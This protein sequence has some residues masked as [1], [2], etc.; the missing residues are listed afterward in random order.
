MKLCDLDLI[1]IEEPQNPVPRSPAPQGKDGHASEAEE[2]EKLRRD[3]SALSNCNGR[4]PIKGRELRRLDDLQEIEPR[5]HHVMVLT[6][7]W[8][9]YLQSIAPPLGGEKRHRP[10]ASGIDR[11][12]RVWI[13]AG[14]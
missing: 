13:A 5:L 10:P 9:E 3:E 12:S 1:Q 6:T 11:C 8:F 2:V 14:R 4:V 7:S